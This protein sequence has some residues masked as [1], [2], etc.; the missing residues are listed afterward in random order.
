MD[1]VLDN[2]NLGEA[3]LHA[4]LKRNSAIESFT[5]QVITRSQDGF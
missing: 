4:L 1:L 2:M 3:E 5:S